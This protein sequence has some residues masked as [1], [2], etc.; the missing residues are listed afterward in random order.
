MGKTLVI[1]GLTIT[2]F[3]LLI[4]L[5]HPDGFPRL[6]GDIY[7]QRDSFTFYFPLGWCILLSIVLSVVLALFGK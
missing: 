1:I 2:A 7:I 6:P 4:S 5:I 3:G